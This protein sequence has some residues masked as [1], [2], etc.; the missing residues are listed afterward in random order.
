MVIEQYAKRISGEKK[1]QVLLF[2]LS[3]C[4]W[5]RKTKNLLSELGVE[6]NYIDVDQVD[7]LARKEILNELGK[8]NERR[9][10]PTL[11]VNNDTSVVGFQEE[12]IRGLL[13]VG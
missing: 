11:V 2:A 13:G 7:E 3:T 9:T 5:C 6:Y 1:A 4:G 12:E 8:W 10:F